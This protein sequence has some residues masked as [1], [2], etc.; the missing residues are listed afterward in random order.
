MLQGPHGHA[1][2]SGD[3][4]FRVG[5]HG[6]VHM[7]SMLLVCTFLVFI[8]TSSDHPEEKN[9]PNYLKNISSCALFDVFM[10]YNLV[11]APSL[12]DWFSDI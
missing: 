3:E 5:G 1:G 7:K 9:S 6:T 11:D 2:A 12:S 4:L 10:A 8:N